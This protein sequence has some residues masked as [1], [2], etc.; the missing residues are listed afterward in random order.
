MKK[1]T[2]LILLNIAL[3]AA[4]AMLVLNEK[5]AKITGFAVKEGESVLV[6]YIVFYDT[7]DLSTGE[8]FKQYVKDRDVFFVAG[9]MEIYKERLLELS[10]VT[11]H[12]TDVDGEGTECSY[13]SYKVTK[14]HYDSDGDGK[15]SFDEPF[16]YG[17][18]T[19][20]S[21][22]VAALLPEDS[23]ELILG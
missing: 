21:G 2:W 15:F 16:V 1:K 23:Y 10:S 18:R 8:S 22:C 20:G 19:D 9:G 12:S 13:S 3:V 14:Y 4:L 7:S 11:L 5:E 6:R 17:S